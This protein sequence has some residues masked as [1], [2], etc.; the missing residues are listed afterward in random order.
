[1]QVWQ[2]GEDGYLVGAIEA[3]PDPLT[4]GAWLIP[5]G[6]VTAAPPD[7]PAG[8]RARWT[9]E[10]WQLEPEQPTRWRVLRSTLVGRLTEAEAE[11]LEALLAALPA[12]SRARWQAVRWIWSDDADVLAAAA[13]L[14]WTAERVAELLARDDDPELAALPSGA[15]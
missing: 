2:V 13:A 7:V 1:M 9:G 14:G 12:K 6:C 15:D 3:E 5:R 10:A 11:A 4:P 8:Q